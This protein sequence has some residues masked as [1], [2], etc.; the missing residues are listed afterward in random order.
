[1]PQGRVKLLISGAPHRPI[2]P[3]RLLLLTG[4]PPDAESI[5]REIAETEERL[6]ALRTKLAAIA[7]PQARTG[8]PPRRSAGPKS[9]DAPPE[10]RTASTGFYGDR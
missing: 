3:R 1:M 6:I 9:G 10:A 8:S 7:A 5:K 2:A 4:P